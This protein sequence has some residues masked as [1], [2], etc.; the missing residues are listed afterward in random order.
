MKKLILFLTIV[1]NAQI[2]SAQCTGAC[3]SQNLYPQIRVSA[4]EKYNHGTMPSNAVLKGQWQR[5]AEVSLVTERFSISGRT[6]GENYDYS[7]YEANTLIE[8][9]NI[10]FTE[11]V[12]FGIN[13]YSY[14]SDFSPDTR[15]SSAIR[16]SIKTIIDANS[17]IFCMEVSTIRRNSLRRVEFAFQCKSTSTTSLVCTKT[18]Y[19][20]VGANEK[21]SQKTEIDKSIIQY[22]KLR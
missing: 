4:L 20:V 12:A 1:L 8:F 14:T 2:S 15:D 22:E 7:I 19:V 16:P 13:T 18:T 17:G 10:G 5:V 6:V 11:N 9:L 21:D 3:N